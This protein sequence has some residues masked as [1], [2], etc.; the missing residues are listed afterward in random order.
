MEVQYSG[1]YV[2]SCAPVEQPRT[3][4]KKK[5]E[6]KKMFFLRALRGIC[7]TFSYLCDITEGSFSV[8]QCLL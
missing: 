6:K 1:L 2:S 7:E 8:L 4:I 3:L 5:K